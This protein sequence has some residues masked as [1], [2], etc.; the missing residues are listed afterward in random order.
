MTQPPDL[1][2]LNSFADIDFAVDFVYYLIDFHEGKIMT[3]QLK[4][5]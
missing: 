1:K 5:I 2:G 3:V 4:D